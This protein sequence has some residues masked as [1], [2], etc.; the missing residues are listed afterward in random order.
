MVVWIDATEARIVSVEA[1][2]RGELVERADDNRH[3]HRS[4]AGSHEGYRTTVDHVFFQRVA[5][6]LASAKSFMVIG[7]ANT[8]TE[9]VKHL[10]RYDPQL[11]PRLSAVESA[12]QMT[13]GQLAD[14]ARVYFTKTDGM[15][16]H[17]VQA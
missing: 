5:N 16:R 6:D 3:H 12:N 14:L 17:P 4:R 7:P 15:I 11:F 9:F 1:N 2:A 13:D 10:H 8:K